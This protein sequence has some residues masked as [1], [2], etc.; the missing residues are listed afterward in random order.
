MKECEQCGM[1]IERARIK[2][3]RLYFPESDFIFIKKCCNDC[4]KE[5]E[6]HAKQ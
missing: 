4:R 6:K 3:V 2:E 5:L 1:I